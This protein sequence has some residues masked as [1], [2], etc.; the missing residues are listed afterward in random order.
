MTMPRGAGLKPYEPDIARVRAMYRLPTA[1]A[2]NRVL[3]LSVGAPRVLADYTWP[4]AGTTVCASLVAPS[5]RASDRRSIDPR[6]P[7]PFA[8]SSFDLVVLHHTLD[9][10]RAARPEFADA[11]M[12]G[13][14]LARVGMLLAPHGVIAGCVS[15]R[16][17]LRRIA[18]RRE[19]VV[20]SAQPA[21]G[22]S[23][24]AIGRLL[25]GAGF[26]S[27][28]TYTVLPSADSP[29]QLIDTRAAASRI[30]FRRELDLL[31]ARL[32]WT[33]YVARRIVVELALNRHLEPS[34]AFWGR[35]A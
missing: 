20:A 31:H 26:Q 11:G 34:I 30:G 1:P 15:N 24:G 17:I 3:E 2:P 35:R 33:G 9:D 6:A 12:V 32:A 18:R 23:Y 22:F 5:G 25:A 29:T 16:S 21:D 10:L 4:G 19:P 14:F 7:L 13:A 28:A 8:T 27:V